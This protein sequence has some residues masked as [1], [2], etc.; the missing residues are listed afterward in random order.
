MSIILDGADQQYERETFE[1]ELE[2]INTGSYIFKISI[3]GEVNNG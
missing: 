2:T 1:E 3:V